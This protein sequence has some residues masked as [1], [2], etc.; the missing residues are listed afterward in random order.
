[1]F[2]LASPRFHSCRFGPA[3]FFKAK[4][5]ALVYFTYGF[6]FLTL[7]HRNFTITLIVYLYISILFS[8]VLFISYIIFKIF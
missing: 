4:T 3:V 2:L 6:N 8:L 5:A 1:M 7:I